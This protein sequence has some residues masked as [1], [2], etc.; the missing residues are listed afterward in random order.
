M[1]DHFKADPGPK[2]F[3]NFTHYQLALKPEYLFYPSNKDLQFLI[4]ATAF[5]IYG[6]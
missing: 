5:L 3:L 2:F 6:C 4:S 1:G